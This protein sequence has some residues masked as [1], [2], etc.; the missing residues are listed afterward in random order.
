MVLNIQKDNIKRKFRPN[1][2]FLFYFREYIVLDSG[3]KK[4]LNWN[5]NWYS[6]IYY[7]GFYPYERS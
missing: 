3:G 7:I 1:I 6:V 2:T 4:L 5:K